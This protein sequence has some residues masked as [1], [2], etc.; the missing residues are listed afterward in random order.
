M[1]TSLDLT[2]DEMKQMVSKVMDYVCKAIEKYEND[3]GN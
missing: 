1:Q 2:T 3:P